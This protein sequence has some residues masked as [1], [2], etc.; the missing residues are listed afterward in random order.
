MITCRSGRACRGRCSWGRRSGGGP[1][2]R[3]WR[4]A[5]RRPCARTRRRR[6]PGTCPSARTVSGTPSPP[7][8]PPPPP[9]SGTCSPPPPPPPPPP[10]AT[11]SPSKNCYCCSNSNSNYSSPAAAA[12]RRWPPAHSRRRRQWKQE[13]QPWVANDELARA[14]RSVQYASCNMNMIL[15]LKAGNAWRE[16]KGGDSSPPCDADKMT[17]SHSPVTVSTDTPKLKGLVFGPIS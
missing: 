11:S 1:S 10:P 17:G 2:G 4:A 5:W 9:R 7:A 16:D 3:R 14:N 13:K 15:T 12:A 8:P 6:T